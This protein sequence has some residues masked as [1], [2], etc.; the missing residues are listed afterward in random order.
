M[1][2]Q[3]SPAIGIPFLSFQDIANNAIAEMKIL[4]SELC[5]AEKDYGKNARLY[6]PANGRDQ[7][8]EMVR[9]A[10]TKLEYFVKEKEYLVS[11]INAFKH[12]DDTLEEK[13]KELSRQ[14]QELKET[15]V[16]YHGK[17][18][19][20]DEAST[21]IEVT[22]L[23]AI[24][25]SA[26]DVPH[27]AAVLY[28][29]QGNYRSKLEEL[30]CQW[31]ETMFALNK[32][33]NTMFNLVDYCQSKAQEAATVQ[34]N[35]RMAD[36]DRIMQHNL[37]AIQNRIESIEDELRNS[38]EQI[39]AKIKSSEA[40]INNTISDLRGKA[41]LEIN[42]LNETISDVR[43]KA[44]IEIKQLKEDSLQKADT[45]SKQESELKRLCDVQLLSERDAK[46]SLVEKE[47]LQ[48]K[49]A[50]ANNN[51]VHLQEELQQAK[52]DLQEVQSN[53]NQ[54]S[55]EKHTQMENAKA[56]EDRLKR[57]SSNASAVASETLA[58]INGTNNR[59]SD[60][61]RDQ[62][63]A[64]NEARS[65]T[66]TL[67]ES[68]Q[69]FK[70]NAVV[71]AAKKD[72]QLKEFEDVAQFRL[73]QFQKLQQN[74]S[75]HQRDVNALKEKL[76][77]TKTEL[78][79][80][81]GLN[82][83]AKQAAEHQRATLEDK[84]RAVLTKI[85]LARAVAIKLKTRVLHAW[86]GSYSTLETSY[87][88]L[89]GKYKQAAE[90]LMSTRKTYATNMEDSASALK[91]EQSAHIL[92]V[93]ELNAKLKQAVEENAKLQSRNQEIQTAEKALGEQLTFTELALQ[94]TITDME[95]A[96]NKL[97]PIFKTKL[98]RWMRHGSEPKSTFKA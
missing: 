34:V 97:G 7:V 71:E 75:N 29:H 16:L 39:S 54:L 93:E 53:L 15:V 19:E 6:W 22:M 28:E 65:Q 81:Q 18:R 2:T 35:S 67:E 70:A 98:L 95:K 68:F 74:L 30:D 33:E 12:D 49:I 64:I 31:T 1:S 58:R 85:S 25:Q 50:T 24:L 89:E 76:N 80:F 14:V 86:K 27:L 66:T 63:A 91:T 45:I 8:V 38:E 84:E 44:S 59:L 69:K 62:E 32:T 46:S 21:Y 40:S 61:V 41:L 20:G 55:I 60:R 11:A 52:H 48:S 79:K 23:R 96:R 92:R 57:E 5:D 13:T 42:Q 88:E 10:R 47:E 78:T 73:D 77:T 17:Q 37:A 26:S 43:G 56:T 82:D 36:I 90:D 9:M 94:N 87:S 51:A 72:K 4:A 3:S 83:E